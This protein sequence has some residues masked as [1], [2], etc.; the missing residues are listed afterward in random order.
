M[1]HTIKQI[2]GV[3]LLCSCILPAAAQ[4]HQAAGELKSYF[5]A[6]TAIA[7]EAM[8]MDEAAYTDTVS[9]R[10]RL[11][12]ITTSHPENE[13]VSA[14]AK[15]IKSYITDVA[16]YA[17]TGNVNSWE[18]RRSLLYN[19][20]QKSNW[21]TFR[22]ISEADHAFIELLKTIAL[23]VFEEVCQAFGWDLIGDRLRQKSI[24]E[25]ESN[26]QVQ[27]VAKAVTNDLDDLMNGDDHTADVLYIK[28]QHNAFELLS[29]NYVDFCKVVKAYPEV[30]FLFDD[31]YTFFK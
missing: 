29:L 24:H 10:Y 26:E 25:F 5:Q 18:K 16:E 7:K 12:D 8:E 4:S 14:T 22:N 19:Y 2:L 11:K 15:D 28:I 20:V 6:Q 1:N 13:S 21:L 31:L 27:Y 23:G 30:G 3:G 17:I 9:G